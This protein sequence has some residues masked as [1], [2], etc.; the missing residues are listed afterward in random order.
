MLASEINSLFP[1]VKQAIEGFFTDNEQWLTNL[2]TIGQADGS[3]KSTNSPN[4]VAAQLL[5]TLE[6]AM[7]IARSAETDNVGKFRQVVKGM[8]ESLN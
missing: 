8:I 5:A 2:V 1:R 7:L 3:F 4:L 6:G